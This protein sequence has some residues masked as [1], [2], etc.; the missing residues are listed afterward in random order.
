MGKRIVSQARGKGSLTYRVRKKA[1]N[2]KIGYP[3]TAKTGDAEI[4]AIIHSAAHS[5][6]LM[7]VLI[8]NQTFYNPAFNQ[9]FV[10]QKIHMG[11]KADE[12]NVTALKHI[13][14]GTQI[15]NIERNPGDGGKMI[16]TAGSSAVVT[17][18]LENKKVT[19]TMPNKKQIIL[20]ENCR[21]TIGIIAGDGRLNKPLVK[22]GTKYYK[23]KAKSKL[24]P[25]VSAVAVNAVDHPFG[26]GR[27]KNVGSKIAKRNAPPGRKVGHIR[28]RR[29]GYR[30]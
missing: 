5:A 8:D 25:R 9:A 21:A 29:T 4:I 11:D 12:G 7:K 10:G 28:P 19:I 30:K 15:Y 6:P 13:Q 14:Q 1:F 26:S 18:K 16:R 27:G 23:M 2:K 22:A 17:K 24:W 20:N 3:S